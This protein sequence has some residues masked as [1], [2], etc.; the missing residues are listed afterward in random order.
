MVAFGHADPQRPDRYLDLPALLRATPLTLAAFTKRYFKSYQ[1]TYSST[2]KP[3]DE[4]VPEL[5]QILRVA[6]LR[7]TMTDVGLELPPVFLTT[8]EL[9][10]TR[11]KS[12]ISCAPTPASNRRSSTRSRRAACRSSIRRISPRCAGWSANR[13]RPPTAPCSSKSFGTVSIRWS[14]S[15]STPARS[16]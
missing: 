11:R 12:A 7:R 1:G 4:M 5:Q 10:A 2:Q 3:R 14:Y 8:S 6:S 16:K 13:R 9:T 15:A